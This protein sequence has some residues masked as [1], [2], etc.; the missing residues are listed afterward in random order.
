MPSFFSSRTRVWTGFFF[1][2]C[3]FIFCPLFFVL[4]RF[5]KAKRF[6]TDP[7]WDP[8]HNISFH[9]SFFFFSFALCVSFRILE[10]SAWHFHLI[11]RF[12][13]FFIFENGCQNISDNISLNVFVEVTQIVCFCINRCSYVIED[14]NKQE[15]QAAGLYCDSQPLYKVTAFL[16]ELT[17]DPRAFSVLLKAV[18]TTWTFLHR[19][20]RLSPL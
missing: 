16:L 18:A 3:L 6:R 8:P 1:F 4:N 2:V 11:L 14:E 15:E 12:L 5:E 10:T 7:P 19:F 20:C 17:C 13:Y 9:I